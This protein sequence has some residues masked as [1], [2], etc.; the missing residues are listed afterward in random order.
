MYVQVNFIKLNQKFLA[1]IMM[2]CQGSANYLLLL[3]MAM[4]NLDFASLTLSQLLN[5]LMQ[6]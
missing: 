2:I 6:G 4:F 5:Y 3:G 1:N